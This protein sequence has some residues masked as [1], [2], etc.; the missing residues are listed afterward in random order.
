MKDNSEIFYS[1]EASPLQIETNQEE[2]VTC[3]RIDYFSDSDS[4][5][6][7]DEEEFQQN[8]KIE[9]PKLVAKYPIQTIVVKAPFSLRNFKALDPSKQ[10]SG[11]VLVPPVPKIEKKQEA[12]EIELDNP[13]EYLLDSNSNHSE[14][15]QQIITVPLPKRKSQSQPEQKHVPKKIKNEILEPT[16]STTTQLHSIRVTPVPQPIYSPVQPTCDCTTDPDAI[17]LK[18][19]LEDMKTMNRKNKG[20]FKIKVQQVLQDILYPDE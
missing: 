2:E 17:F 1:G 16:S 6:S 7:E 19:L 4:N 14:D 5:H 10:S 18:S 3:K 11:R 8:R 20:L 9:E 12:D 13:V 15:D